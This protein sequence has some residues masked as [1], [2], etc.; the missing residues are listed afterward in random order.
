M[1]CSP[2]V[3]LSPA[4]TW[5]TVGALCLCACTV[6]FYVEN[7]LEETGGSSTGLPAT[8]T[9]ATPTGDGPGGDPSGGPGGTMASTSTTAEPPDTTSSS[10]TGWVLDLGGTDDDEIC[11]AP[12]AECDADSDALDHAL[13]VNCIGGLTTAAVD[14]AGTPKSL[15]VVQGP[16]GADDTYAPRLGS[17]A[18]L[19]STG[20]AEHVLLD[21]AELDKQTDCSQIGLPCPSTAYSKE[22]IYDLDVLP[23][24]M[25]PE[26]IIC[27]DGQVPPGPGDCSKTIAKQ[28]SPAVAH[29]YSELRLTAKA[30]LSATGVSLQ[31]AF[32]TAEQPSR[33]ATGTFNDLFVVW[34]ESEQWT[35]NIA[36]HAGQNLPL[37]AG[38]GLMWDHQW[39]PALAGFA[40][41]EHVGLDWT[42]LAAE[43]T[44]GETITLVMA[45]FDGGDG[46]VDTAVL[47]DDLRWSCAI[48]NGGQRHP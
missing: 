25:Q 36:V 37:A 28:W 9:D 35:G 33:G 17:R 47:L 48:P 24:P 43:V 30:P 41:A 18:V 15:T 31:A 10:S 1:P 22:G 19:L 7:P 46:S 11:A 26:A 42:T 16:L 27:I 21:P 45:I 6:P 3:K 40:F 13:G 20:I 44:P 23:L 39:D 8:D 29:D 38:A 2:T 4:T 14:I 34:L 32:F 12:P 5:L